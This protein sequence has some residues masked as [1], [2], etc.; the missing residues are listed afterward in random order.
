VGLSLDCSQWVRSGHISALDE[1]DR[2][3]TFWVTYSL[4]KCWGFYVGRD[5]GLTVPLLRASPATPNE[6]QNSADGQTPGLTP[7]LDVHYP[8]IDARA[9]NASWEWKSPVFGQGGVVVARKVGSATM[10]SNI[11]SAF[12]QTSKLMVLAT[13]VM[14]VMW[15]D[16]LLDE[17][18][19][20]D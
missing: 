13:K 8:S 18:L 12:Y 7:A 1:I 6:S 10:Q 17:R 3:W 5:L 20:D 9:D 11:S 16:C 2:V 19:I 4:D 15:V 14:N